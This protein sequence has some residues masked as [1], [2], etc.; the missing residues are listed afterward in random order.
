MMTMEKDLKHIKY[1]WVDAICV[2]QHPDRRKKTIY[3]MSDIY[4]CA[5][6][7]LAVPDLHS[8]FLKSTMT[9]FAD[10]IDDAG[11]YGEDLYHL[12]HGNVDHL[13]AIEEKFLDDIGVPNELVLRKLLFEYTDYFVKGFV[14]DTVHCA[15]YNDVKTLNHI[16]ETSQISSLASATDSLNIMGGGDPMIDYGRRDYSMVAGNGNNDALKDLHYCAQA[17]CPLTSFERH[18]NEMKCREAHHRWRNQEANGEWQHKIIERNNCIR[19]TMEFLMDLIKDWSSRVWVIS[20]YSIAK[21]N[22]NL[23]YWFMQ[24][25]LAPWTMVASDDIQDFTFFRFT[26]DDHLPSVKPSLKLSLSDMMSHTVYGNF[27]STMK[28]QLNPQ[29]FLEM[30]LLSKASKNEDRFYA[31]LP[32]TYYRNLFYSNTDEDQ[33]NTST[34]LL[35]KFKLYEIMNTKDRLTLLLW[36]IGIQ[37]GSQLTFP[38]FATSALP[39]LNFNP[40]LLTHDPANHP[41]NFDLTDPSS[42]MFHHNKNED[43][44]DVEDAGTLFSYISVKPLSYYVDD[45]F[46][47]RGKNGISLKQEKAL[48]RRLDIRTEH[49]DGHSRRLD[50]VCIP[51]FGLK[52]MKQYPGASC[53]CV[54]LIGSFSSRKWVLLKKPGMIWDIVRLIFRRVSNDDHTGAIFNIY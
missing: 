12:I 2:D 34:L 40:D 3:R 24:I 49:N 17:D 4:K 53:C 21:E 54:Y 7:I 29:S 33:W 16:Y 25:K 11:R 50:Y 27:H 44:E 39:P 23:K 32:Q 8:A 43:D 20:E 1:V 37:R 15:L 45:T 6:F 9:K 48:L 42:V 19:Q 30:I 5:T 28:S 31:I 35:V 41:C 13:F 52:T 46:N 26:F 22:N 47:I 51:A 36:S 10:I 38:T 14:N 18:S